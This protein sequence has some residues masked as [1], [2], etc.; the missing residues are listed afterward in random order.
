MRE[1][2]GES[3]RGSFYILCRFE[4]LLFLLTDAFVTRRGKKGKASPV[5]IVI[6]LFRYIFPVPICIAAMIISTF[7]FIISTNLYIFFSN[8]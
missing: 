8:F 7:F 2:T 1:S 3:G 4:R 6:T 5:V